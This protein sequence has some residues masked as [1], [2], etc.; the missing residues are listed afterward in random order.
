MLRMGSGL[1]LVGGLDGI[2]PDSAGPSAAWIRCR[3][4]CGFRR[5]LGGSVAVVWRQRA[6]SRCQTADLWEEAWSQPSP[7][8]DPYPHASIPQDFDQSAVGDS[9]VRC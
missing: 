2:T 7:T 9:F 4:R 6:D 8:S 1:M 3:L 5:R